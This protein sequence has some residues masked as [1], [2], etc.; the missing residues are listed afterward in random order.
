[1]RARLASGGSS[2]TACGQGAV[3]D[4]GAGMGQEGE[5]YINVKGWQGNCGQQAVQQAS[6]L[7]STQPSH[8]PTL[9]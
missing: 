4:A 2:L 6:E 8:P 9:T 7:Q 3:V 1:M 5:G